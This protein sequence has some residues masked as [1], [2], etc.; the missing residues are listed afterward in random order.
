M[1]FESRLRAAEEALNA[2][3]EFTCLCI[4]AAEITEEDEQ[5]IR[6]MKPDHIVC[7]QRAG[8]EKSLEQQDQDFEALLKRAGTL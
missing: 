3:H 8:I 4:N 1:K 5:R 2:Q 6:E 7:I